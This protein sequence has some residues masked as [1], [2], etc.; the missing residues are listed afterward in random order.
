MERGVGLLVGGRLTY[1]LLLVCVTK[2]VSPHR[3]DRDR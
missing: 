2:V 1:S 3:K